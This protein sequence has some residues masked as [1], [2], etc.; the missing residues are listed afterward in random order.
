MKFILKIILSLLTL[1]ILASQAQAKN[2]YI[3]V[4]HGLAS[5][6]FWN[7]ARNGMDNACEMVDADCSYRGTEVFSV[8]A[9]VKL[10]EQA[11]AENPDGIG[12]TLP[13]A[14]GLA[15]VV[16]KAV[17]TGVPVVSFNS[18][19]DSYQELGIMSH[20]GQDEY[21]G[22]MAAGAYAATFGGSKAIC[23]NHQ[24]GNSAL[25]DRCN[26]FA[27]GFGGDTEVVAVDE[28]D[29]S[30]V[31][32]AVAAKINA[33]VD[34]IMTLNATLINPIVVEAIEE[35]GKTGIVR[36]GTNDLSEVTLKN[37]ADGKVAFLIDQQQYLQGFMP[38]ILFDQ[39]NK[40]KVIP[41]V[42]PSGPNVIK[43]EACPAVIE[44]SAA[45]YR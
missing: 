41:P 31:K 30:G 24:Q 21:E 10:M 20:V 16:R 27:A 40:Y 15:E 25:D 2:K 22:G 3:L 43:P 14:A 8:D 4:A 9:M 39:W 13:D 18:G 12:I 33:G 17:A 19:Y 11:I 45:G 38:I 1:S 36:T 29:L 37:C 32:S 26:G 28:N 23:L 7:A 44:L 6:S 34:F 35:A 5:D 42:V